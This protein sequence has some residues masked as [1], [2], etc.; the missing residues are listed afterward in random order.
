MTVYAT[1]SVYCFRTTDG[2]VSL[3][4]YSQMAELRMLHAPNILSFTLNGNQPISLIEGN[5][6]SVSATPLF[7]S[8]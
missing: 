7:P 8:L 5:T 2:G 1:S 4:N 3:D 6:K